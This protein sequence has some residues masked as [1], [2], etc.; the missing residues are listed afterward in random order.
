MEQKTKILIADDEQDILTIMNKALVQEGYEVVTA[1]DGEEAWAKIQSESPDVILLDLVMPKMHGYD[2]LKNL[3]Q[4]PPSPKWQPVIIIS[5]LGQLE[6][7]K[8]GY[9]LEADH[10]ITKPCNMETVLK[11]IRI[12][13]SLIPQRRA[14]QEKEEDKKS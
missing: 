6:D 5:A 13:M 14:G 1:S 2:V 4:T 9:S 11:A 8:K 7:I 3:R 10:Y 12:M